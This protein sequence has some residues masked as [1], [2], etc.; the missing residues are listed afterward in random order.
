MPR[1]LRRLRANRC[2]SGPT[3]RVLAV[4]AL[5]CP[6]DGS[7]WGDLHPFYRPFH[8]SRERSALR[9]FPATSTS[10]ARATHN[11]PWGAK[12]GRRSMPALRANVQPAPDCGFK[13]CLKWDEGRLTPEG[14]R[15]RYWVSSNGFRINR[16]RRGS[17]GLRRRSVRQWAGEGAISK[18][19]CPP[20]VPRQ[21]RPRSCTRSLAT[22]DR[23]SVS[24]GTSASE[25][26]KCSSSAIANPSTAFVSR[27]TASRVSGPKRNAAHGDGSRRR[28]PRPPTTRDSPAP[29]CLPAARPACLRLTDTAK[30]PMVCPVGSYRD[31]GSCEGQV[32]WR[33]P[34]SCWPSGGFGSTG[35]TPRSGELRHDKR[36]H[37]EG[38]RDGMDLGQSPLLP[39]V[40]CKG[41][42]RFRPKLGR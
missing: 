22:A 33:F 13:A 35:R 6:R 21:P 38:D 10:P 1:M 31:G 4:L 19:R 9:G 23:S 37:L 34:R 27:H 39:E 36:A 41:R 3:R 20:F 11:A 29:D 18:C 24:C 16:T 32:L 12:I 28:R 25:A 17:A 14:E 7:A 30:F 26:L 40:R 5:E 15:P 2:L 42:H 8:S